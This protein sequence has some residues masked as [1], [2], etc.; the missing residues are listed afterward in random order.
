MRI[1]SNSLWQNKKTGRKKWLG[2]IFTKT[3]N[4]ILRTIAK[5]AVLPFYADSNYVKLFQF[6]V[7]HPKPTIW[8]NYAWFLKK[9]E[10]L[11]KD[12]AILL[13]ILWSDTSY[14]RTLP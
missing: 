10:T 6:I 4:G 1:L 9:G 11:A 7:T 3:K 12:Q 5:P 13:K 2:P 14:Q 8:E